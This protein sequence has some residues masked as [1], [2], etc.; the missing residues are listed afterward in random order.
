MTKEELLKPRWKVISDFPNY[1]VS[2]TGLVKNNKTNKILKPY[3]N[4]N[5]GYCYVKLQQEGRQKGIHIAQLVAR[6]FIPNPYSKKT[7]NHIDGNKSNN[8]VENLAWATHKENSQH[9]FKSGLGKSGLHHYRS[10]FSAEDLHDIIE[11]HNQG[12]KSFEIAR[13]YNVSES[14]INS[15]I[16]GKSYRNIQFG[17]KVTLLTPRFEVVLDYPFSPYKVGAIIT[18]GEN[19]NLYRVF[20]RFPDIFRLMFWWEEREQGELPAFIKKIDT[21]MIYEVDWLFDTATAWSVGIWF[22]RKGIDV[23]L[24]G[25]DQDFSLLKIYEPSSEEEYLKQN[26]S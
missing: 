16:V 8:C 12:L 2:D 21:G 19:S 14:P 4:K 15:I 13:L 24:N 11:L 17:R 7:I 6:C 25:Q 26:N 1:S 10:K 22:N 18:T 23:N 20:Q 3:I 9:A 5:R